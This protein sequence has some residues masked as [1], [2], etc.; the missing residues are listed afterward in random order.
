[1]FIMY[2]NDD[3]DNLTISPRIGSEKAEPT[4]APSI[5]LAILPGTTISNDSMF[6]LKAVC[7][8]C[9]SWFDTRSTSQPMI[10]AFGHGHP[11]YSDSNSADLKR[12]I[13]YGHFTMDMVAATG[14]GGVPANNTALRNV[15][16]DGKMVRDHD[17]ANLAHAIIGCLA[18][19]IIW[20]L[21]VIIA[22]FFKNIRIHIGFSIAVMAFLIVS[23]ALGISTSAQFNRVRAHP[24][25]SSSTQ[26][27]IPTVKRLQNPPPNLR[28]HRPRPNPPHEHS[29]PPL[30][31][32]TPLPP[33]T[34]PHTP[35][36]NSLSPPCSDWRPRPTSLVSSAPHHP[37]LHRRRTHGL[38]LHHNPHIMYPA[39][40]LR[41]RARE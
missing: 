25:I 26:T 18:L 39:P 16:L 15:I 35:R 19:F 10:Y 41:I 14:T 23:Y 33:T 28:L 9:R 13:R 29:P 32:K 7:R 36:L 30:N 22:G 40:R 2:P 20:P 8:N 27:D 37:R 3:G 1:M 34:P 6:V 17:R 24:L 38:P 31:L 4:Y 5:D 12:H 21:N 11:L